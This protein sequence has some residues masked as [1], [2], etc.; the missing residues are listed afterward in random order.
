ME[1]RYGLLS[2]PQRAQKIEPAI[3]SF[4]TSVT[5]L[6]FGPAEAEQAAQIRAILKIQG[7]PGAYNALPQQQP[8]KPICSW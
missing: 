8:F 4:L 3:T 5:I 2:N 7:Q 6:I 1:L